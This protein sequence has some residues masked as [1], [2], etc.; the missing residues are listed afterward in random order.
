MP[1]AELY[2]GSNLT[3]EQRKNVLKVLR[4]EIVEHDGRHWMLFIT[5]IQDGCTSKLVTTDQH[6]GSVWKDVVL[7]KDKDKII[8]SSDIITRD[9]MDYWLSETFDLVGLY[10]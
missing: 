9:K 1:L 5:S 6:D 7:F 8:Q 10:F 3:E 2:P 4:G